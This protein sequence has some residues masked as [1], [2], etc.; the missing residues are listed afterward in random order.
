MHQMRVALVL[1]HLPAPQPL[2]KCNAQA[3]V[4]ITMNEKAYT[5][6]KC[7]AILLHHKGV[8]T[9]DW[10]KNVGERA[11]ADGARC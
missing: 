6:M 1:D 7:P 5:Q 4:H 2:P 10:D 11:E 9:T 3:P 8:Q